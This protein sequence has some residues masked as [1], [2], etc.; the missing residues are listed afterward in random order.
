MSIRYLFIP[1]T[2]GVIEYGGNISSIAFS[3]FRFDLFTGTS[4]LSEV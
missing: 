2:N 3:D 1:A 4:L